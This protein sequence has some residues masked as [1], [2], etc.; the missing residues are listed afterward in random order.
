[1]AIHPDI[2]LFI[3]IVA[4]VVVTFGCRPR[5]H[6]LSLMLLNSVKP[7]KTDGKYTVDHHV[8]MRIYIWYNNDNSN[9]N[10]NDDDYCY[11]QQV[12]VGTY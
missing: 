1:M 3:V 11:T 2:H 7:C 8:E 6:L 12:C 9:V 5:P 10:D 4:A